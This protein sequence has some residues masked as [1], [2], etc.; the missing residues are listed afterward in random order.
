MLN[1]GSSVIQSFATNFFK[2]GIRKNSCVTPAALETYVWLPAIKTRDSSHVV[3]NREILSSKEAK[4]RFVSK[5][6]KGVDPWGHAAAKVS[7]NGLNKNVPPEII[8]AL[9]EGAIRSGLASLKDSKSINSLQAYLSW[10]PKAALVDG[11]TQEEEEEWMRGVSV[12][13]T[14]V[15]AGKKASLGLFSRK[16]SA[17]NGNYEADLAG[18][19]HPDSALTFS[20]ELDFTKIIKTCFTLM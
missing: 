8:D 3:I 1:R 4:K 9:Q 18:Y 12:D 5:N 19:G 14:D 13:D 6:N 15:N 17:D 2:N 20:N 11:F 10:Y 16:Y 7:I